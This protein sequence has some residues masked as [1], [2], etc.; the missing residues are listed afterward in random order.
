VL[1][2][3]P[4]S[5]ADCLEIWEPEPPGTLRACAALNGI[6]LHFTHR[7]MLCLG[8][9][10]DVWQQFPVS[11]ETY[12][13]AKQTK[14]CTRFV[15][16]FYCRL[17]HH[18][19]TGQLYFHTW[20]TPSAM[21]TGTLW[22]WTSV[23]LALSQTHF[24]LQKI[25]IKMS[26]RHKTAGKKIKHESGTRCAAFQMPLIQLRISTCYFNLHCRSHFATK[27]N[28]LQNLI[29]CTNRAIRMF[30][31]KWKQKKEVPW[32]S[33]ARN[34]RTADST[35]SASPNV[36]TEWPC[37]VILRAWL[38]ISTYN[39]TLLRFSSAP[40]VPWLCRRNNQ[41]QLSIRCSGT[42]LPNDIWNLF[43]QMLIRVGPLSVTTHSL[44]CL[45]MFGLIE[46]NFLDLRCGCETWSIAC[47]SNIAFKKKVRQI[48]LTREVNDMKRRLWDSAIMSVIIW[49]EVADYTPLL[50]EHQTVQ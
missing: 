18:G 29:N 30:A 3:L 45:F 4:P 9:E 5:C 36:A 48:I 10:L 15:L 34:T 41:R 43:I 13:A 35:F 25:N 27:W 46:H 20:L 23:R 11:D 2:T 19:A 7:E 28:K 17:L 49:A 42:L 21:T 39:W 1:T 32:G 37:R 40:P 50:W 6:A 33:K 8:F 26:E 24:T 44:I 47:C 31:A 14:S 38:Q 12:L 16:I 22:S